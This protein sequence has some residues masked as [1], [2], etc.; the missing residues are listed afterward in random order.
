MEKMSTTASILAIVSAVAT[1]II[2]LLVAGEW[3]SGYGG[4]QNRVD[5]VAEEQIEMRQEMRE[6]F[7]E[8]RESFK[9]LGNEV[10]TSKSEVITTIQEHEHDQDTGRVVFVAPA[11]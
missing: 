7:K 3:V 2:L 1:I 9:E 4:L 6:G 11:R 10:R 8:L 5:N